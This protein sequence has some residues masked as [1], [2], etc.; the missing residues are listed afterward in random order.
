MVLGLRGQVHDKQKNK[1]GA[2]LESVIRALHHPM[3]I[4]NDNFKSPEHIMIAYDGSEAAEKAVDMVASS[5][6]YKGLVCH[7]VCV[8]D[9]RNT[10]SKL[11]NQA[12]TKLQKIEGIEIIAA[13]L[14]GK[15]YQELCAYQLRHDIDLTVMGAFSHSR[16][17]DVLLGSFTHKMLVNTK[18]P[19]LLLR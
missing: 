19:L 1:I 6:L 12:S 13:T 2:K 11:L 10:A 7:L 14:K 9:N 3:L 5:P 18:K 15:A 17:H 8:N 16:A 4:V